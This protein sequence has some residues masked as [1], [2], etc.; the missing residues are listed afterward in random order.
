MFFQ[1]DKFIY[2]AVNFTLW[3]IPAFCCCLILQCVIPV[4]LCKI[5][6]L[7][8]YFPLWNFFLYRIFR[9]CSPFILMI[10]YI[11]LWSLHPSGSHILT[12][13]QQIPFVNSKL[14]LTRSRPCLVLTH[15]EKG[16]YLV[17]NKKIVILSPSTLYRFPLYMPM[18]KIPH[19]K[20]VPFTHFFFNV[21][22]FRI[23]VCAYVWTLIN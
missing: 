7:S 9:F 14:C 22:Y 19:N 16:N 10:N 12:L 2:D 18:V 13:Y 4:Y 21:L 5:F 3:D 11:W 20:T 8:L 17:L 23:L 1:G 15:V 6:P